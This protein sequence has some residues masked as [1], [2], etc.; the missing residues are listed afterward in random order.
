M[1]KIQY[2]NAASEQ[3]HQYVIV[4]VVEAALALPW[5]TSSVKSQISRLK[6]LKR[7]MYGC[8]ELDLLRTRVLAA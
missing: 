8:A 7:A 3:A 2:D 5:S 1:S 6:M 4:A